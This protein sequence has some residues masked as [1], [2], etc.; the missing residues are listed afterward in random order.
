MS[1]APGDTCDGLYRPVSPPSRHSSPPLGTA[2]VVPLL[3]K[4]PRHKMQLWAVK[5]SRHGIPCLAEAT[6][7]PKICP[8][9]LSLC[10]EAI[11]SGGVLDEIWSDWVSLSCGSYMSL[12]GLS[13]LVLP[14]LVF[15][16]PSLTF[17]SLFASSIH[18]T[19]FDETKWGCRYLQDNSQHLVAKLIDFLQC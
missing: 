10:S 18:K 9:L 5:Y 8:P 17:P 19:V 6:P 2:A 13:I 4:M 14:T 16:S 3:T 12:F 1:S 15:P 11:S 7:P